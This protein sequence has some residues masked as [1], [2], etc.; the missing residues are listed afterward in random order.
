MPL[1]DFV[2][3]LLALFGALLLWLPMRFGS[4]HEPVGRKA[5]TVLLVVTAFVSILAYPRFGGFH[6]YGQFGHHP[7]HYHEIF[8]Y[9]LGAKYFP[10]LGYHNLYD[11]GY[12]AL[13]EI[14]DEG[15]RVPKIAEIR[16]LKERASFRYAE[17][18][19][20]TMGPVCHT[21]FSEERWLKFKG[22]L[23]TLLS[24]GWEEGWWRTMFFDLGFNPP[25][26]WA[27]V[28]Y[29][30]ANTIPLTRTTI[31]IMPFIDM[32]LILAV[33][34]CL[35]YWAFGL[36][37]LCAYY[38]VFGTNW[39]ADYV[40][41]GGSFYRQEWFFFLTCA[42]CF[43]R[44]RKLA[45]AGAFFGAT[46]AMRIFPAFFSAGAVLSLLP[47]RR[48]EKRDWFPALTVAGTSALCFAA[49]FLVSLAL[50]GA[51][52]WSDFF[53]NI[54]KHN[55]TFFVMHI[56]FDKVA[57]FSHSIG[58][59]NFWFGPGL[60]RFNLWQENLRARY[61][62]HAVLFGLVKLSALA[63]S[64][65]ACLRAAP[66]EGALILGW[67]FLF[68]FN[69]PANY[70]YV[71][72]ALLPVAFYREKASPREIARMLAAML[73][74]AALPIPS[75]ITGDHIVFNGYLNWMVFVAF[76]AI[77]ATFLSADAIPLPPS[78]R[79]RFAPAR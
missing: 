31:S 36:Y 25:P 45:A 62:K 3:V 4:A 75:S 49:F 2:R 53:D 24:L 67:C 23:R 11:C 7:Y 47:L 35:V 8:H 60:G 13:R 76:V 1:F 71:F 69:I 39:L 10:E 63:A 57:V 41:T 72:L 28:G 52:K 51:T 6:D 61:D 9:Y 34:G 37:P 58:K 40:W 66:A 56:G 42:L 78:L 73:L 26:S 44:R 15:T 65:L 38:I 30:L 74:V 79:R 77:V 21:A 20:I 70:Y 22:D 12:V 17:A 48:G 50:F 27:V 18:V 43:L 14:G 19:K 55:K 46:A 59:Q 32:F 16:S 54:A 33:G 64:I 5:N 29:P 68:F